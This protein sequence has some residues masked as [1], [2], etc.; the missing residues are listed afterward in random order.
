VS[1]FLETVSQDVRYAL[2]GFRRTP[3]FALTAMLTLALPIGGSS[4][5]FSMI[6]AVL[7]RSLPWPDPDR[8][9]IVW[10]TNQKQGTTRAN[11]SSA[12]FFDWRELSHSFDAL[13]HWRVVYFNISGND[14][15]APERVQGARVAAT[16]LPLL[17]GQPVLGRG[18]SAEEEQPG[19]DR[20]AILS[21][22]FWQRRFGSSRDLLGHEILIDGVPVTV[23]GILSP[24]FR[25]GQVMNRDLD[26]YLPF[27]NDHRQL[28]RE[29]HA[30]NIYG[31]LR[32]TVSPTDAEAEMNSIAE[33]LELEFPATNRGWRVRLVTLPEAAVANSRPLLLT[34]L[35]SVG[36]V[37]LIACV[38]IANLMLARTNSRSREFAVRLAVGGSRGRVIRQLL[39]ES[40]FLSLLGGTAGLLLA[41]WAISF[42]MRIS[43]LGLPRIREFRIDTMVL[44]F[45]VLVSLFAGLLFGVAPALRCSKV[46]LTRLK[47]GVAGGVRAQGNILMFA[48]VVLTT[49]LLIAG[50][51]V[52]KGALHLVRMNR[53]LDVHQ[54]LTMQI[55]LPEAKYPG[56]QEL[57]S[58]FEQLLPRVRVLPGVES[59]SVVNYPP[60][61]LIGTSVRVEGQIRFNSQEAPIAHYWIVS[62]EYF[63]TVGLSLRSGR[64]FDEHDAG[65]APA[66]VV[67]SERLAQGLFPGQEALGKHLR[68]LFPTNTNAFWIP[69]SRNVP[70]MIVGIVPD[71]IEEGLLPSAQ[72]QMYLPYR[73]NPTRITHLLVRTASDPLAVARAVRAEVSALDPNQ[74]VFDVRTLES[75]TG[76]AFSRQQVMA[77]LVGVLAGL[78]LL[79][80]GGGHLR[81]GR[82]G[83]QRADPGDGYPRGPRRQAAGSDSPG[84]QGSIATGAGR[85]WDRPGRSR[86]GEPCPLWSASRPRDLGL[87]RCGLSLP[88]LD[89]SSDRSR[90]HP[91]PLGGKGG[92]C[93][94]SPL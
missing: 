78:A 87:P 91:R 71:I 82:I 43:Y 12:N 85:R 44:G 45:T 20:V 51:A 72:P 21:H 76:E 55:W 70:F 39:T 65:Q 63:H 19:R 11:P 75:V 28:S 1:Q 93:L 32:K 23:V 61:G 56:P 59:A 67:I 41:C 64:L 37:L 18:F 60:L 35:A 74:P 69:H 80:G 49:V 25:M 9:V 8:L 33:R 66:V 14:R 88:C 10:E 53:G 68:P 30:M 81:R 54:V 57:A 6:R 26:L 48:E 50:G 40:L 73:Q 16:F 2:R 34:L 27:A 13:A 4:A 3:A 94:R 92:P 77:A 46:D 84:C 89:R 31:R 38:N 7:L 58:F 90:L 17:G 42:L 22:G 79:A 52:L 47:P 29:D 62:P 83:G 5:I 36:I 86:S 24:E 15:I